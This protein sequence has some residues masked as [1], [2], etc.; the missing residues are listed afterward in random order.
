MD[1]EGPI[2][3]GCLAT[4]V[5]FVWVTIDLA[6]ADGGRPLEDGFLSLVREV[7]VVARV[8]EHRARRILEDQDAPFAIEVGDAAG[9]ADG[10]TRGR[11]GSAQDAHRCRGRQ[12]GARC[13]ASPI[14]PG[15]QHR[16][17]RAN[18]GRA[19]ADEATR[20][21]QR[22]PWGTAQRRIGNRTTL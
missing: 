21:D 18:D 22:E 14:A 2:A 7:R 8:D 17:A 15:Q 9:Q 3:R 4:P 19:G 10:P 20:S 12:R 16:E 1:V 13:V 11:V 5:N 6:V